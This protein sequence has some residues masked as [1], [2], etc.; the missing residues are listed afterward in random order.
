LL[1]NNKD[2]IKAIDGLETAKSSDEAVKKAVTSYFGN[3][4]MANRDLF[5]MIYYSNS[6]QERSAVMVKDFQDDWLNYIDEFQK[7][8]Y[9]NEVIKSGGSLRWSSAILLQKSHFLMLARSIKNGVSGESTGVVAILIDEEMIDRIINQAIYAQTDVALSDIR[10]YSVIIDN[11]GNF[12][13][14]PFKEDIGKNISQMMHNIKPLDKIMHGGASASDYAATENQ[15]IYDDEINHHPAL[16]TYKSIG[17]NKNL[18]GA[19]GWHLI[20]FTYNSFL[21]SEVNA[22]GFMTLLI[23]L[24][25]A[26]VAMIISLYVSTSISRPLNKVVEAMS[27]AEKGDLTT[28]VSIKSRNELGILGTSFN[29]MLEKIGIL[30]TDTKQAIDAMLSRSSALEESSDQSAQTAENVAVAM[31]EISKGTMEQTQ[32]AEKSANQMNDLANQIDTVVNKAGEVEQITNATKVLSVKSKDVVSLLI[33]KT[34]E[35][36]QIT[37]E[38]VDTISDLRTSAEEIR[39]VTEVITNLAEQTNLLGLNASI[40]AARAGEMGQG[41]AVVAEEV[42][43]LAAQSRAATKSINNIL[44]SIEQK[45]TASTQTVEKAHQIVTEQIKAVNSA[46][47]SFDEIISAMDNAVIKIIDMNE[48]VKKIN[49]LKELTARAI[50]NISSISEETAASAEEVS[51]SSQEQTAGAEQVKMMARELRHMAEQLVDVT[52]KFQIEE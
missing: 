46:Q 20:N 6:G 10:H 45:T 8:A 42:N 9:Y 47:S 34:N 35:T 4:M 48:R 25:V 2:F 30:I 37:N 18:G 38:I 43:K 11:N 3:Y 22:I 32:E 17:L 52:S 15:G 19:S 29:Q 21:F 44:H 5:G 24:L 36:D 13:S 26:V 41:F 27:R 51:A 16:V 50:L 28:R 49:V 14:S 40:E 12:I 1:Y 39:S 33:E 7:T 23:A 31:S